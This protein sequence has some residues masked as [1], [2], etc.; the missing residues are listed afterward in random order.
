MKSILTVIRKRLGMLACLCAFA[1]LALHA[2]PAGPQAPFT[3]VW[4]TLILHSGKIITVDKNNDIFEAIAIRGGK[5]LAVGNNRDVL[6]FKDSKTQLI[7]LHGR[8]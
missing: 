1:L 8:T 4:A 5:I 6:R 2:A 7:D 3:G